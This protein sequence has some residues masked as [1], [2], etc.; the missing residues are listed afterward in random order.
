MVDSGEIYHAL[1]R[2][3]S[4]SRTVGP[5]VNPTITERGKQS[6]A[7]H[8]VS[9]TDYRYAGKLNDGVNIRTWPIIYL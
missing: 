5:L 3:E 4:A 8:G 6:D 2:P 1:R 9:W 7:A